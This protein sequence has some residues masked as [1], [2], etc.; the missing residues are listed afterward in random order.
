[1][2]EERVSL[3]ILPAHTF[4]FCRV[5]AAKEVGNRFVRALLNS[6]C[7]FQSIDVSLL[8]RHCFGLALRGRL[9]N[10]NVIFNS[11]GTCNEPDF[12][13]SISLCE[14]VG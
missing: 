3:S 6:C 8:V 11:V 1:M 5:N 7:C 9:E 12:T 13:S 14:A 2:D 10:G 4:V